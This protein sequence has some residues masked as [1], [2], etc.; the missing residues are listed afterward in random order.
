MIHPDGEETLSPRQFGVQ[1]FA[2][3]LVMLAA[4]WV[5]AKMVTA[6]PK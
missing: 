1:V 4:A 5:L 2:D 6:A 3:V